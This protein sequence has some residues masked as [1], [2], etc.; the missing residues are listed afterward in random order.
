MTLNFL[1]LRMILLPTAMTWI[2]MKWHGL[3]WSNKKIREK[4]SQY[5]LIVYAKLF[6]RYH[7]EGRFFLSVVFYKAT[8]N[9]NKFSI[10]RSHI[11][12]LLRITIDSNLTFEEHVKWIFVKRVKNFTH[13]LELPGIRVLNNGALLWGPLISLNSLIVH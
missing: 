5:F 12:E 8:F 4:T 6:Q 10:E 3:W 2:V 11:D 13:F 1:V 7:W 9:F